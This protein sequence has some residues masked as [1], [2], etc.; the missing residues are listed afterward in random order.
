MSDTSPQ[1]TQQPIAGD[2]DIPSVADTRGPNILPIALLAIIAAVGITG[3]ILQR[4]STPQT[5]PTYVDPDTEQFRV[6]RDGVTS[7]VIS[8]TRDRLP[9][10]QARTVDAEEATP[11]LTP[12]QQA[13]LAALELEAARL[14][15]LEQERLDARKRSPQLVFSGSSGGTAQGGAPL[16]GTPLPAAAVTPPNGVN[17]FGGLGGPTGPGDPNDPNQAFLNSNAGQPAQSV[18][19]KQLKNLDALV[20]QGTLI[21]GVLE[22]ALQSD[23]PGQVRAVVSQ[24]IYAHNQTRILIPRGSRIIGQYRSGVVQ[25]QTRVFVIWDRLIT[26]KGM[27]VQLGSPGT[28][29]LGRAGL[30]GKVDNHFFKRFGGSVLLSLIDGGIRAGVAS[31]DNDAGQDIGIQTGQNFSRAAELALENSIN[32]PPT[33]HVDQGARIRIFVAR[34]LDFSEVT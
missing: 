4:D 25:G 14:V 33:I 5:V 26:P 27:S 1:D 31:I 21:A 23:L 11:T 29:A 10:D 6:N 18:S 17:Q 28:D 16:V 2:R 15:A 34:D 8:P 12:A 13:R 7:P 32:I 22:T 20:T 3:F 19:A 24:N 9:S 30:G